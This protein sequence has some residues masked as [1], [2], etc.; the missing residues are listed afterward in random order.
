MLLFGLATL[1]LSSSDDSYD[2]RV[3]K[4]TCAAAITVPASTGGGGCATSKLNEPVAVAI[5]VLR[6]RLCG[7]AAGSASS[8][9]QPAAAPP[10]SVRSVLECN[11]LGVGCFCSADSGATGVGVASCGM[12]YAEALDTLQQGVAAASCYPNG[13]KA[14]AAAA[15]AAS[16]SSPPPPPG[17]CDGGVLSGACPRFRASGPAYEV[18]APLGLRRAQHI[19]TEVQARGPV[20][21]QF[22]A[23]ANLSAAY[24]AGEVFDAKLP[25]DGGG[26]EDFAGAVIGW[27][28]GGGGGGSSS[29]AGENQDYWILA[30]PFGEAFGANGTML[31]LRG[32][33]L[34]R[35]EEA[36]CGVP[37]AAGDG[38]SSGH[39]EQQRP[40][41]RARAAVTASDEHTPAQ[42]AASI[43][44]L[45]ARPGAAWTA[46]ASPFFEGKT[47][48]DYKRLLGAVTTS[49]AAAPAK[50]ADSL[51]GLDRDRPGR[52]GRRRYSRR[53]AAAGGGAAAAAAAAATASVGAPFPDAFDARQQWPGCSWTI[54]NQGQC[55]SCWAFGAVESLQNRLCVGTQ[56]AVDVPLSAQNM[57]ECAAGAEGCD[58]SDGLAPPWEHLEGAGVVSEACYPYKYCEDPQSVTCVPNSTMG[59]DGAKRF[60][61]SGAG[62]CA[63]E[64][65]GVCANSTVAFVKFKSLPGAATVLTGEALIKAA[66]VRNGP[67]ECTFQVDAAFR[68][69]QSGV[70]DQCGQIDGGHAIKIVGWGTQEASGGAKPYWIVANSWS[71]E[72][73]MDGYFLFE[74][75][76]NLCSMEADCAAGLPSTAGH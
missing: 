71:V 36:A 8:G 20:A 38:S 54:R 5:G 13:G 50:A 12:D 75:G 48:A 27:G 52:A 22:A 56:G 57:L 23:P 3:A 37:V 35:V 76:S 51:P 24:R 33:N 64:E 62:A 7:F 16:S 1:V 69:Y 6:W 26:W 68:N 55:G 53:P 30:M 39:N 42:D 31:Y 4:P 70:F 2:V 21:V 67:V 61:S 72:W 28:S 60:S 14:A 63:F 43:A 73:G 65:G 45:N 10:L 15:A 59:A 19:Q 66:I 17:G 29:G 9:E 18:P 41:R 40:R 46:G 11:E 25:R 74:R 34:N 32:A 47:V 58:G 44:A 49:T